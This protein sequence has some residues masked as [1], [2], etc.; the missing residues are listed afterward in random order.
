MICKC[1]FCDEQFGSVY[2]CRNHERDKHCADVRELEMRWNGKE[3]ELLE[4]EHVWGMT[5][6]LYVVASGGMGHAEGSRWIL[7][8]P[9]DA[10]KKKAL[11]IL[12]RVVAEGLDKARDQLSYV[13][14]NCFSI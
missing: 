2:D 1:E 14:L 6:H 5:D 4:H 10:S 13:M 8:K 7:T 11:G 9:D 3:W 12:K